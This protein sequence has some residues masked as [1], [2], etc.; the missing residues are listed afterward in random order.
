MKANDE[1]P[2][3]SDDSI[4]HSAF[5]IQHSTDPPLEVL[6]ATANLEVQKRRR[7]S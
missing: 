7:R 1:A 6:N 2:L 4:H 5:K 3:F